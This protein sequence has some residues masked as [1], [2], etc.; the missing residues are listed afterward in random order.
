MPRKSSLRMTPE[1]ESALNQYIELRLKELETSNGDR[2]EADRMSR[3]RYEN[4]RRDRVAADSVWQ[5]SN[6]PV[7]LT[8]LVVD[9]FHSRSWDEIFG[10][11]PFFTARPQG[12]SDRDFARNLERFT[13]YKLVDKAHVDEELEDAIMSAHLQRAAIVKAIFH[14]E[15]D[16]F[17]RIDLNALHDNVTGQPVQILDHGFILEDDEFEEQPDPAA[18]ID[19]MTGAPT[20]TRVHLKADPS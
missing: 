19:P 18:P 8:S 2:I 16:E 10:E 1:Q 6:T 11:K 17:E 3:L 14:E 9:Y 5:H 15:T 12:P 4:D 20:A 13:S 7:P